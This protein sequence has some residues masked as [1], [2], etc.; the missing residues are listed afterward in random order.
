MEDG[1]RSVNEKELTT[2][3]IALTIAVNELTAFLKEKDLRDLE[4]HGLS[5]ARRAAQQYL[6]SLDE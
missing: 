5:A 3:I 6:G 2:S 1:T 4:D